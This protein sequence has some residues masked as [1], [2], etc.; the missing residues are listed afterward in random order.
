MTKEKKTKRRIRWPLLVL[1]WIWV[2]VMAVV[3]DLFLNV[4]EFEGIRPESDT[5]RGM[6]KAAHDIAGVP[7]DKPQF[8][9]WT[10]T[11]E[12]RY[13]DGKIRLERGMMRLATGEF[14]QHGPWTLYHESGEKAG[15][16]RYLKGRK[17][18]KW[19]WWASDGR[20]DEEV[21]YE[22]GVRNGIAMRWHPNGQRAYEG[23]YRNGERDGT[24]TWWY[25]DG[26]KAAFEEYREGKL[27]GEVTHWHENGK[28]AEKGR[29][30]HGLPV[31]T[32]TYYHPNGKKAE[33]GAFRN[34]K[35]H[36]TWSSWDESG[37]PLP[38]RKYEDGRLVQ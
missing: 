9:V 33:E 8:E 18:G 19:K 11:W 20:R 24:W 31:G 6:R 25:A 7:L 10:G 17:T 35:E 30:E 15:D 26:T 38:S 12:D 4:P 23:R 1:L 5:Y 28:T 29:Y 37:R 2:G 32:V 27:H 36:G 34:G 3:L 21:Q 22:K 16:G 14:V 13:E